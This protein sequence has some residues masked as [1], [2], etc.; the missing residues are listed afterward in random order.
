M[1][2]PE[3]KKVHKNPRCSVSKLAEYV[4][5]Q[6]SPARR[7]Q[8]VLA[9]KIPLTFMTANYMQ[10]SRFIVDHLLN[11]GSDDDVIEEIGD[12]FQKIEEAPSDFAKKQATCSHNALRAFRQI[13]DDLP[14]SDCILKP[15]PQT[16][17]MD[18]CGVEVSVRPELFLEIPDKQGKKVGLVK[19]YFSKLYRL[20]EHSAGVMAS[21]LIAKATES[22]PSGTRISHDHVIVVDVL[23]QKVFTAPKATKRLFKEA[24]AACQEIAIHWERISG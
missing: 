9:Q 14:I 15:G 21:V 24:E 7:R 19:F 8:I 10:A 17:S 18:I 22:M 5:Q 13:A 1:F 16:W 12:L 23:N 6:S 3:Q 11:N 2:S 4:C 20:D